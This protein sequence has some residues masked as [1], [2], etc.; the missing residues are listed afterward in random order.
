MPVFAI[1]PHCPV[2]DNPARELVIWDAS[3]EQKST[4]PPANAIVARGHSAPPPETTVQLAAEQRPQ[5]NGVEVNKK[6]LTKTLDAFQFSDAN[7]D[8]R[9]V[10]EIHGGSFLDTAGNILFTGSTGTG[11][12]HLALS[13]AGEVMRQGKHGYVFTAFDLVKKL[14]SEFQGGAGNFLFD[15]AQAN[16][17]VIDE[18]GY[19]PISP[20]GRA[21]LYHLFARLDEKT[22]VIV[23]SHLPMARWTKVFEDPDMTRAL[24]DRFACRCQIVETGTESW[25]AGTERTRQKLARIGSLREMY[26]TERSA[27]VERE[28]TVAA[29]A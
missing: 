11:K 4:S 21:L 15:L 8:E 17:V 20:T 14:E 7:V 9:L 2:H 24:V 25:R 28:S 1:E 29:S 13:V 6:G 3:R 22:S 5:A 12:T 18:L 26:S 23:T 27:S 16:F 19:V 10:R